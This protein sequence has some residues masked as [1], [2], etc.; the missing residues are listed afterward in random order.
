MIYLPLAI[1]G[2]IFAGLNGYIIYK[3]DAVL[4]NFIAMFFCG[5]LALISAISAGIKIGKK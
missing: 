5:I 4:V 2:A 1:I 3:G